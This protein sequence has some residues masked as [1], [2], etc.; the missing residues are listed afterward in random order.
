[1]SSI[2]SIWQKWDLHI[3]TPASFEWHGQRFAGMD[4]SAVTE[5]LNRIIAQ[6]E[7]SDVEVFA[8]MDYWTF[9][10]Y[11]KLLQHIEGLPNK[12]QKLI[13]PGIEFRMEAPTDFRLNT[14]VIFDNSV[15]KS[16]L[17]G[18][19]SNLRIVHTPELP[20]SE[21]NFVRLAKGF[22]SG[23]L[24]THGFD[25]SDRDNDVRM[26]ELGLKTAVITRDSVDEALR[27]LS[28]NLYLKIQPYDTSDGL[29]DLDWQ[30]HPCSDSIL[31]KWADI[32]ETRNPKNI[33]LFDWVCRQF[34][35]TIKILLR[36]FV[37]PQQAVGPPHPQGHPETI[38]IIRLIKITTG[39]GKLL[40][41]DTL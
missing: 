26:L 20:V 38:A 30:E 5:C 19:L 34:G 35:C 9:D 1:M 39:N 8:V 6:I 16:D 3:H 29:E 17:D 32:F 25:E 37:V 2:G 33:G 13:L 31:M 40:D 41:S 27:P 22:D 14:H 4:E 12:P 15:S 21:E 36:P 11:F 24:R 23:K 10:G 18:F 7:E 28:K